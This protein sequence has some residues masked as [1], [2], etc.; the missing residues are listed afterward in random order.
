M[1]SDQLEQHETLAAEV[2]EL[3]A[4]TRVRATEITTSAAEELR[5]SGLIA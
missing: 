2:A 1:G 4:K 5:E 3:I